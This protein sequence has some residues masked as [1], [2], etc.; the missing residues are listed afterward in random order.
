MDAETLRI[1]AQFGFPSVL[2]YGLVIWMTKSLNGKLDKLT[3]AL[4]GLHKASSEQTFAI[5]ENTGK[6]DSLLRKLE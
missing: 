4:D 6:I 1:I 3:D 2:A 5:R